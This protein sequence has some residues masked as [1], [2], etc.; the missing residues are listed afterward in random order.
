[1]R[2]RQGQAHAPR[3][4]VCKSTTRNR[5]TRRRRR[6]VARTWSHVNMSVLFNNIPGN[7]LVPFFYAEINS[8]GTPFQGN[9]RVLLIG[10]KL[11]GGSAAAA[12][13][14]ARSRMSARPMR[15]SASD[16]CCRRCSA[17]RGAMRRFSRFGR[18]RSPIRPARPPPARSRSPR[19]ASPAP[20][21]CTSWAAASRSRSTPPTPQA[22]LRQGCGGDQCGQSAGHG[23]AGR[24]HGRQVQRHRRHVG[25]LGNAQEVTFATDESNVLTA[26]NTT[27]VALTGG[28]GVPDLAGAAREPRR[29]GI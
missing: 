24:H 22:S 11:A 4:I 8:G 23:G 29:S 16:R 12:P 15:F 14:S 9:P 18:C 25:A 17:S 27:V 3:Q 2:R 20:R 19:P 6:C 13:L 10:Q 26:A 21:S 5:L 1:M 28:N 7:Q